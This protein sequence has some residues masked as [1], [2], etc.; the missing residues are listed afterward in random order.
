METINIPRHGKRPVK[1]ALRDWDEKLPLPG[2]INVGFL[3]GHVRV[4]R[5]DD[6]WRLK[7]YEEYQ[8]PEKRPGLP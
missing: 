5:L 6:L 2:A 1:S 4:V 7:W 8:P 3:D